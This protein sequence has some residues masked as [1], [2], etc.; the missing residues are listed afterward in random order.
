MES[1]PILAVWEKSPGS[2]VGTC[3]SCMGKNLQGVEW[4]PIL[5]V[6]EK[7]PGSGVGTY[8]SSMGK[9]LL[10]ISLLGGLT[11]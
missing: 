9:N 2:G 11:P 10:D 1:E 4:E 7:S 8:F 6:L 5:A 3:F